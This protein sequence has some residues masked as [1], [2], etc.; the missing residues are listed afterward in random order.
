MTAKVFVDTNILVYAY[1]RGEGA[2]HERALKLLEELWQQN[3][4]VL[5]TQVLQEFYVTI[6][7]KVAR[8][9]SPEETRSLIADYLTWEPIVND[10]SALLEAIDIEHRYQLSFW[11]ALIVGAAQRAGASVLYSE[12][13]NHGQQYGSLTARNP[14]I[15]N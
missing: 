7:R 2:K 1:D 14:F 10:G 3:T 4:G 11:D 9:I 13:F 15:E 6:C 8:P 5:S 12:D